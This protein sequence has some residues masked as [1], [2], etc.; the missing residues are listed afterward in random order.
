MA[1]QAV[2]IRADGSDSIG[3]GHVVRGLSLAGAIERAGGRAGFVCRSLGGLAAKMIGKDAPLVRELPDEVSEGKDAEMTT[4]AAE[5]FGAT[6][7]VVDHYGLG[8]RWWRTLRESHSLVA[9]DDEGR[10]GLGEAV[11]LVINQNTGALETWYPGAGQALCGPRFALLRNEFLVRRAVREQRRNR[12]DA[13]ENLLVTLGGADPKNSTS[14]V[15]G[16]LA[17]VEGDFTIH[18]VVG[19]GFIHGEA[20]EAGA[21]NDDRV[22]L[23]RAPVDMAELMSMA[24]LGVTGGGTT[25]YEAAFLG[26]PVA[27]VTVAQNQVGLVS[28]MQ[29]LSVTQGLGRREHLSEEQVTRVL[30]KLVSDA[31]RRLEMSLAGLEL[32]DGLGADRAAC[33]ILGIGGQDQEGTP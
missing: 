9:I 25:L 29:D 3:L 13:V 15:L 14:V 16:G 18:T 12:R 24:D 21:R 26:L 33:E 32:V 22:R 4:L 11:D 7:V 30:G 17:R 19:P 10:P 5:G 23:H 20:L 8:D 31:E 28:A 27:A 6:T 2:I 1:E